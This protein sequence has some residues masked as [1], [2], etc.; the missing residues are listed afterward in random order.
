MASF[1]PPIHAK[2]CW[3]DTEEVQLG[4]DTAAEQDVYTEKH[5][6]ERHLERLTRTI[7]GEIIP[8]LVLAHRTSSQS[9]T[10]SPNSKQRSSEPKPCSDDI[11][12]FARLV[13]AHDTDV[14]CAYVDALCAQDVSLETVFLELLAPTARH[15]GDLWTADL[16][17]FTDV[18]VALCRLQQVLRELSR[19]F[20]SEADFL[21]AERRALL[22]AAPGEQHT[23]GVV[24]VAEFL[25]RAGWHVSDLAAV[26]CKND[27]DI[28][29]TVGHEWFDVVGLSLSCESR[30]EW[31]AIA[32]RAIR[33][34]SLNT[35]VG[36]LVGGRVFVDH[37]ELVLRIG[38]DA[39]AMDGREAVKRAEELLA[40][41][42]AHS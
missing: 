21:G 17:S 16:C 9:P 23:F 10:V 4:H 39:T 40:P 13:M 31:L 35:S 11:E 30:L 32:I 28:V 41:L 29:A 1:R 5:E 33:R 34:A 19:P 36:V 20:Q 42:P 26:S 38:A 37:P 3:Q 15:L 2:D 24:M 6:S 7:E 22:V 18:T 8:R 25:R 14:A 12:E 27:E